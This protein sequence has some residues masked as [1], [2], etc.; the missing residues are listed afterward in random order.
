MPVVRVAVLALLAASTACLNVETSGDFAQP[1]IAK[2]YRCT[3]IDDAS[4]TEAD[5]CLADAQ[6]RVDAYAKHCAAE[7][8]NDTTT[9][10]CDADCKAVVPTGACVLFDDPGVDA[11]VP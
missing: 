7:H 2:L 11:G 1:R 3:L 6:A 10:V 4:R 9:W 8:A 5:E